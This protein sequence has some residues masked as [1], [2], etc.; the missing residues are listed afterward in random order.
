MY[1]ST[2]SVIAALKASTKCSCVGLENVKCPMDKCNI[3]S[4]ECSFAQTHK[5]YQSINVFDIYNNPIIL[6]FAFTIS[7]T[8]H[9]GFINKDN[10]SLKQLFNK[11]IIKSDSLVSV[12]VTFP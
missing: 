8:D 4:E 3:I 11:N 9:D 12:T 10:S 6:R 1:Y 2:S 7:A 5:C